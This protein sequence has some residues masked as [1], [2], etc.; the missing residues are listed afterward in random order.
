MQPWLKNLYSLLQSDMIAP[1]LLM[2]EQ[3]IDPAHHDL[4]KRF[5]DLCYLCKQYYSYSDTSFR[6]NI[7]HLIL[8]LADDASVGTFH[9]KS[10]EADAL[11]LLLEP[12]KFRTV[13]SASD[14]AAL[15]ELFSALAFSRPF[16]HS[17]LKNISDLL[18]NGSG[19]DVFHRDVLT[20]ALLI[21]LLRSFD[22]EVFSLF[23]EMRTS[24]A[25]VSTAAL[26]IV[27]AERISIDEKLT[28]ELKSLNADPLFAYALSCFF[29]SSRTL[30]IADDFHNNLLPK[31]LR[32]NMEIL[33]NHNLADL[34]GSGIIKYMERFNEMNK[35]GIDVYYDTFRQMKFFPFFAEPAHW[36]FPLDFRYHLI[37]G[38]LSSDIENISRSL[39]HT[40]ICDSDRYSLLFSMKGTDSNLLYSTLNSYGIANVDELTEQ[41]DDREDW[42]GR[43]TVSTKEL[44]RFSV[45]NLFRFFHLSGNTMGAVSPFDYLSSVNSDLTS[46]L[47]IPDRNAIAL[48]LYEADVWEY[49]TR[50][51][52]D[53][54]DSLLD[55]D[56]EIYR[57]TGY[58]LEQCSRYDEAA[59]EYNKY[60]IIS[61]DDPWTLSH[62][63]NAEYLAGDTTSTIHTY[64]HLL[65]VSP[66]N[67]EALLRLSSLHLS[68]GHPDKAKQLAYKL[69]YQHPDNDEYSY[70]LGR[71]LLLLGECDEACK[72]LSKSEDVPRNMLLRA[73]CKPELLDNVIPNLIALIGMSDFVQLLRDTDI[74][75]HLTPEILRRINAII[76]KD[77]N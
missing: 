40:S 70:L 43:G 5:A 67:D 4:K 26:C 11:D 27:Y 34:E 66:D 31:L 14:D 65:S 21:R 36:F 49:A 13:G 64:E 37:A 74:V 69:V 52:H 56:P 50:F 25:Y 30:P 35:K 9:P 77:H 7:I 60:D 8:S 44:I 2:V 46:L 33:K 53:I 42:Q 76:L 62:L 23:I 48:M 17:N 71:C 20:Y 29:I 57:K 45:M 51:W 58:C 19:L 15:S 73:F 55:S 1:A 63:A 24:I 10:L 12:D 47:P 32:Q 59:E 3:N 41:I 39:T 16:S 72:Y 28:E 68:H 6:P 38:E 22:S 75:P 61:P 54:S 18:D